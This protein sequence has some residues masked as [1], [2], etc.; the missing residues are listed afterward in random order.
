MVCAAIEL[1]VPDY[2]GA[3]DGSNPLNLWPDACG[4]GIGAGLFQGAPKNRSDP[5]T[6]YDLLGVP[7]WCTKAVIERRYHDLVRNGKRLAKFA[8]ER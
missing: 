3:M 2:T 4:F 7:T 8:E 1:Q 6:H 5:I